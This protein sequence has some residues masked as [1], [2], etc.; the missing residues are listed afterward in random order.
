MK[1][2]FLLIN[3]LAINTFCQ[4]WY[5]EILDLKRLDVYFLPQQSNNYKDVLKSDLENVYNKNVYIA[6]YSFTDVDIASSVVK[7]VQNGCNV[8]LITDPMQAGSTSLDEWLESQGVQVR[9]KKS[10][11]SF[12]H[13]KYIV[14]ED[15]I[16]WTGS[17]NFSASALNQDNNMIR[18]NNFSELNKLYKEKFLWLW[19]K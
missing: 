11:S 4:F 8:Y 6:I 7:A 15:E 19:N 12:M 1:K 16:L 18:F 3:F 9:R 5:V 14:I 10:A 17:A 13:D 2:I